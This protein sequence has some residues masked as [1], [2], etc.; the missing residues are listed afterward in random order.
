M[1][2][3]RQMPTWKDHLRALLHGQRLADPVVTMPPAAWTSGDTLA[4]LSSPPCL[5]ASLASL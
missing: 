2:K 1:H 4:H 3:G 5:G